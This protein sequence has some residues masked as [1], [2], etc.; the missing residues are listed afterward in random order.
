MKHAGQQCGVQLSSKNLA[1]LKCVMLDILRDVISVCES[2]GIPLTMGG[3]TCLGAVRHH[4]YIPWDDDLDINMARA[5]LNRFL[6]SFERRFSQKY[7]IHAP[8]L[9]TGYELD[10][11]RIRRR[12][13]TVRAHDDTVDGECGAYIEI[14]II[15][16]VPNGVIARAVHGFGSL[17]LG[18]LLSCRRYRAHRDMYS[19]VL[20]EDAGALNAIRFK[21]AVGSLL[22]FA[23]VERWLRLWDGWNGLCRDNESEYVTI[24]AGRAHYF[25]EMRRRTDFFP[26]V[27]IAFEALIVPIPANVDAYLTALYGRDYMIPP[28][29]GDRE[30]HVVYEFDLGDYENDAHGSGDSHDC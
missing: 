7:W 30:K 4:G 17:V 11:I 22:S 20:A 19:R 8:G 23:S 10:L 16:S 25:R 13:T 15:E 6:E 29:E 9:T 12:G 28:P 18:F 26:A 24:P 27:Y 1:D 3:G 21:S 14:F 2:E 5:D